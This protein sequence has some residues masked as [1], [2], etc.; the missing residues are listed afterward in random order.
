MSNQNTPSR[1][2]P[3]TPPEQATRTGRKVPV[4]KRK[5][6]GPYRVPPREQRHGLLIVNTGNGKGK[7]TA[8]LGLLLRATGRDMRVGMF[9][10][11]K[12]AAT[13]YGEH[14]AAER[15]GVEIVP[16]GD[17]FT[18]LTDN[19]AEDQALA[20]QGWVRVK[21]VLAAGT[22]DVLILDELT[23]CLTYGWLNE[24]EVVTA[25]QAR[26]IGTHVVI[27]GRDAS[28]ALIE[29]ADLVTE[30]RVIKHP[31]REQGIAAQPGIEL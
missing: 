7:T 28:P 5:Q 31:Y 25:L 13:R 20:E 24:H 18:W 6:P 14:I 16:L 15:L 2:D 26:P 8:A 3:L 10:F 27:T 11:I 9:Q 21:E 17:G 4:P 12:S 30:M 29:A 1:T 19:I 22:Y 23:Y